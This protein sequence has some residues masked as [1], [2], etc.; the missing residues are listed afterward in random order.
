MASLVTINTYTYQITTLIKLNINNI[1]G[2][3]DAVAPCE[4]RIKFSI[5]PIG[6][7]QNPFTVF[8]NIHYPLYSF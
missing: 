3:T 6:K 7:T 4:E 1:M 5:F 8:N 2:L